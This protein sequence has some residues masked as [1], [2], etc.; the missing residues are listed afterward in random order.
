MA[1]PAIVLLILLAGDAADPATQAVLPAARR[2]L[3]E[4]AVV[5]VQQA[6]SIPDNEEAFALA[7]KVHALSAVSVAWEDR[8]HS[9]VRIRVYLVAGEQ[10]RDYELV[11]D[12]RDEP[13]E[14]GRA[15]GL[16]VTPVLTRAIAAARAADTAA[17][18]GPPRDESPAPAT[19][20]LA[21]SGNPPSPSVAAPPTSA[22]REQGDMATRLPVSS[23]APW[24]SL[25]VGG[26]ASAGIGGNA[27][28]AGPL[29]GLRATVVGPVAIHAMGMARLGEVEPASATSTTIAFGAGGAWRVIR[30][31]SGNGPVDLGL[32]ADVLAM[33]HALTQDAAG[34]TLR[35]A[36]WLTAADLLM[37]G[38]WWVNDHLE[39][40][41]GAG[42]EIATGPTAITVGGVQ[43][44]H[45]PV[46]RMLGELGVRIPF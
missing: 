37:E 4:D 8:S 21:S 22:G 38:A 36:R 14:R 26:A 42:V 40:A 9:R 16:A 10:R 11:F 33:Q 3:G 29:L 2:P 41:V 23:R 28:G 7:R 13:G 12:P 20:P 30:I 39:L 18:V 6:E 17:V 44:D 32:R 43:V 35:R 5:L 45:I 34:V 46:G 19:Q 1:D 27:L 24:L 31:R 25:D 15:I